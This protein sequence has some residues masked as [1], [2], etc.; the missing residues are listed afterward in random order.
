MLSQRSLR[1][2]LTSLPAFLEVSSK[3]TTWM[4]LTNAI[5]ALIKAPVDFFAGVFGGIIK[6]NHMDE[7][8]QCVT[9]ADTLAPKVEQLIKDIEG[10]HFIDAAKLVTELADE[11]P[12]MLDACES[13]GP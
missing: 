11:F 4:R 10:R 3:R 2:L 12:H 1:L 9:G 7:I 8:E 13:M 6:E 5:P